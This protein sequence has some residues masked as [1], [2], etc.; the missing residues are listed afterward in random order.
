MPD[1]EAVKLQQLYASPAG[2]GKLY[3]MGHSHVY[4]LLKAMRADKDYRDSVVSY[5]KVTRVKLAAFDRF[6]RA[7]AAKH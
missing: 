2:I 5:G 7:Y 3:D 4:T 1:V 6:W